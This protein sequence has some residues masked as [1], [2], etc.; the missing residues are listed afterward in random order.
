MGTVG[1]YASEEVE[2]DVSAFLISMVR[3]FDSGVTEGHLHTLVYIGQKLKLLPCR[4]DFQFQQFLPFCEELDLK[5]AML[6]WNNEF[7]IQDNRI[8]SA[9]QRRGESSAAS[10]TAFTG[11]GVDKL[12]ALSYDSLK[13]LAA[14]LHM[15]HDLRKTRPEAMAAA[16]R[17]FPFREDQAGELLETCAGV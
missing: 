12:I 4:Y 13:F 9:R 16:V 5:I 10:F 14:V 1:Q 8:R 3:R 15:E 11:P 7:R 17:L 2:A 6:L